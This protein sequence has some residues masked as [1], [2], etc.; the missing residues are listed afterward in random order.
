MPARLT[1]KTTG[2]ERVWGQDFI[3]PPAF[4]PAFF[5]P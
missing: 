2:I 1:G 3:L 4:E 5:G